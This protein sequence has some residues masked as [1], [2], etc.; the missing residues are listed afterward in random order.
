MVV[1]KQLLTRQKG[2]NVQY[3]NRFFR[4]IRSV[5][6]LCL[7][8]I[9]MGEP[10]LALVT[11]TVFES[12]TEGYNTFRIP[13]IIR[14]PQRLLAFCEGRRDGGGDSGEIDL[15]LKHSTDGGATWS[16]LSVAVHD[17][18]FTC[19]NPAPVYEARSGQVVLVWTK[20]PASAT[21]ARILTGEDL[22]RTVWVSRSSDE[23]AT[24]SAPEE[25]SATASRPEWRWYATGPG[26]G[27]QLQSGRLLIP[28]NHSLGEDYAGWFSH[29]I[30]SD[31]GG[32]TWAIG[33]IHEG[34]TNESTVAE[35][36]GG[37]VYQ[38]M[39]SYTGE[40]RRRVSYS[41]DGGLSWATDA[42]D[43][44]L[45]EP[46]CQASVLGD[47]TSP[48]LLFSNPASTKRENLTVRGSLDGGKTWGESLVLHGGPSAYSDLVRINEET[49]GCLY[50][51]GAKSPYETIVFAA[52]P[53][54]RLKPG[55][56]PIEQGARDGAD[57]E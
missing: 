52:F 57:K 20:N 44:A 18:G 8:L 34:R 25:I 45:V 16:P 47:A 2:F 26:H 27:I 49:A 38:N 5:V 4:V 24:W 30:Y 41:E 28:A 56:G 3:R 42:T 55:F 15:V 32:V 22:P 39:R 40:H 43:Q 12:G 50:E 31:D 11:N 35:L 53:L 7:L 10:A 1:L 46:V 37:R 21:E 14:A 17:P 6:L 36:P 13:A 19:G 29:V 51:G 33:G 54:S 9:G 48:L 23:G